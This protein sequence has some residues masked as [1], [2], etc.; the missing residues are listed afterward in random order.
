MGSVMNVL[1]PQAAT[2][3]AVF[4]VGAVDLSAIIAAWIVGCSTIIAVDVVPE[5]L[6][7][8]QDLGATHG[9][10]GLSESSSAEIIELTRGGA[11]FSLDTTGV[12]PAVTISINCVRE[13]S[14]PRSRR[15]LAA[16]FCGRSQRCGGQGNHHSR[17]YR[18]R[19]NPQLFIPRM[20]GFFRDGRL[21]FDKFVKTYPLEKINEAVDDLEHGC[22]VKPV[23]TMREIGSVV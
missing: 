11:D 3:I 15:R 22:V 5:R 23:L 18:G 7:V 20:I 12:P 6:R 8:A 1:R 16:P 2:S 13:V 10:S 21:P 14:A 17:S 4:G 9:V 19:C